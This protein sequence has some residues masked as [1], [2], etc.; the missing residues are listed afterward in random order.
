MNI[1]L[2]IFSSWAIFTI[3]LSSVQAAPK[4]PSPTDIGY[5]EDVDQLNVT[6]DLHGCSSI[7]LRNDVLGDARDQGSIGWC[8]AHVAADLISYKMGQKISVSE[9]ASSYFNS[10]PLSKG[11]WKKKG[12]KENG[13]VALA[14]YLGLKKGVCLE[15]DLPSGNF[16]IGSDSAVPYIKL[17]AIPDA[18][19]FLTKIKEGSAKGSYLNFPHVGKDEFLEILSKNTVRGAWDQIV[20]KSCKPRMLK[21]AGLK[22]KSPAWTYL[23]SKAS[24]K[25][26]DKQ[27]ENGNVLGVSYW[28]SFLTDVNAK[29]AV[30]HASVIL[31]RRWNTTKNSCEYLIRNSWGTGCYAYDRTLDCE[32]GNIWVPK[33]LL[34]KNINF[35]DYLI[36]K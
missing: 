21:P 33:E 2:G 31:G 14:L 12:L 35:V 26:I 4:A 23:S 7:D 11:V 20:S 9:L 32:K 3:L 28:A 5:F 1:K 27:L 6:G 34:K 10:I 8:F 29:K 19:S 22:R 25:R 30:P 18:I 17:P 36:Y 24:F 13:W 16:S 15:E